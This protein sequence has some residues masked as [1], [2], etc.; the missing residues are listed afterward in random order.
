MAFRNEA[1]SDLKNLFFNKKGDEI[2]KAI[3]SRIDSYNKDISNNKE[4][5][6]VIAKKRGVDAEE[7]ISAGDDQAKTEAYSNK[8][9]ASNRL[10]TKVALEEL[11]ED[12]D[13]LRTLSFEI[14]QYNRL[15]ERLVRV[16]R[17]ISPAETFKL[18]LAEIT[19]L[20]F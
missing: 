9:S 8:I 17:N 11:Q 7:I 10:T 20:G 14:A 4:E 3:D 16:K 18:D 15:I 13:R 2:Q 5:I 12:M 6:S 19:V 1:H